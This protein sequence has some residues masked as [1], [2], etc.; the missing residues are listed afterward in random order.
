MTISCNTG[1]L[2]DTNSNLKKE[3][4]EE[5]Q[6]RNVGISLFKVVKENTQ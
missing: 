1:K 5:K 2:R 6:A 3:R 4:K